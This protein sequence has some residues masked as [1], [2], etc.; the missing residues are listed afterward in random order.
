MVDDLLP[1]VHEN[2]RWHFYAGDWIEPQINLVRLFRVDHD[3]IPCD[4]WTNE[5]KAEAHSMRDLTLKVSVKVFGY[6]TILDSVI[7]VILFVE[8]HLHSDLCESAEG[9]EDEKGEQIDFVQGRDRLIRLLNTKFLN[10]LSY[11]K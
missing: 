3:K 7:W 2:E 9:A 4:Q 6:V 8:N 5:F 1:V 10:N 11:S